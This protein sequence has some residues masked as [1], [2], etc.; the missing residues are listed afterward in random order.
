MTYQFANVSIYE[1]DYHRSVGKDPVLVGKEWCLDF[2]ADNRLGRY[3]VLGIEAKVKWET[4][5]E[6]Q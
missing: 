3:A 5:R 4:E 2:G 1:Y 6:T